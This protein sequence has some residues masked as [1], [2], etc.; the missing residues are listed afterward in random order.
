MGV[1]RSRKLR[2]YMADKFDL[3]S[4]LS[5]GRPVTQ[6][7]VI[8]RD[9]DEIWNHEPTQDWL[10]RMPDQPFI[11]DEGNHAP[12]THRSCLRLASLRNPGHWQDNAILAADKDS[13]EVTEKYCDPAFARFVWRPR[14]YETHQM[15]VCRWPCRSTAGWGLILRLGMWARQLSDGVRTWGLHTEIGSGRT[16]SA[17]QHVGGRGWGVTPCAV[18]GPVIQPSAPSPNC[19]PSTTFVT[20]A[21]ASDPCFRPLPTPSSQPLPTPGSGW[22]RAGSHGPENLGELGFHDGPR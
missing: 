14:E 15:Q 9:G 6:R 18:A 12:L 19:P 1:F 11:H 2:M 4:L 3:D 8:S 13:Y 5:V 7:S 20:T 21:T 22:A 10:Q 17:P 16:C